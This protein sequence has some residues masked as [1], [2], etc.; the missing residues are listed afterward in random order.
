L[1]VAFATDWDALKASGGL[2]YARSEL[3][4]VVNLLLKKSSEVSSFICDEAK[5]ALHVLVT[6]TQVQVP[7]SAL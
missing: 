7:P 2:T 1:H 5:R 4:H 3:D 6:N